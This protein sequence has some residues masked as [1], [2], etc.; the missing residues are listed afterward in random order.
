[1]S[2]NCRPDPTLPYPTC[3]EH[4]GLL[5]YPNG[6]RVVKK[7]KDSKVDKIQILRLTQWDPPTGEAFTCGRRAH[8]PRRSGR[9]ALDT[10]SACSA[11]YLLRTGQGEF[12]WWR[13]AG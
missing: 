9:W 3:A 8:Y 6:R 7:A 11:I 1:M 5:S 4:C 2:R 12:L 10:L 13:A